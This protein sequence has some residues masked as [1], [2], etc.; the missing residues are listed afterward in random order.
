MY[1]AFN[2]QSMEYAYNEPA[3]SQL[4]IFDYSG[5]QRDS[6]LLPSIYDKV[7]KYLT[8]GNVRGA[9]VEIQNLISEISLD[10]E[11][12]LMQGGIPDKW[13]IWRITQKFNETGLYGQYLAEIFNHIQW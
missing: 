7:K 3:I 10:L 5:Y 1:S 13:I 9:F 4:K 8:V 2:K 6:N 12:L 11:S